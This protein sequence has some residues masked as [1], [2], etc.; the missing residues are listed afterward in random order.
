MFFIRE[1]Y[2][3]SKFLFFRVLA[4]FGVATSCSLAV[5]FAYNLFKTGNPLNSG[6]PLTEF[7]GSW[8]NGLIEPVFGFD[9]G[10][11]WTN[12]WLLPYLITTLFAWKYL[13]R[14][15]KSLLL[16]SLFLF[17]SSLLIYGKWHTWAGDITYGAR[18]QVHLVPLF[19]GCNTRNSN[20][21][22]Y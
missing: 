6:I 8:F 22:I 9:K 2:K 10:I 19:F 21:F 16:L 20:S 7:R 13:R 14:E 4:I 15:L 18:F 12:P 1:T 5:V 17:T 11:L 3:R